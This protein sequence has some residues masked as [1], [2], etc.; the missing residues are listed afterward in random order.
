M[1]DKKLYLENEDYLKIWVSGLVRFI[2]LLFANLNS[3]K[4]SHV[5]E[6][7]FGQ[8]ESGMTAGSS[9]GHSVGGQINGRAARYAL[10]AGAECRS[11]WRAGGGWRGS[12]ASRGAR[13][14]G[15]G[16]RSGV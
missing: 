12:S 9:Q 13:G 11:C 3:T 14:G 6:L 2:L 16:E 10:L 15:R 7:G 1:T 5:R 4:I 8:E